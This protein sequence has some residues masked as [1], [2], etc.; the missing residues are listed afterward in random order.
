MNPSADELDE[1]LQR[2]YRYALALT[3][4]PSTAE[5]LVQE[6]CVAIARH[7]GPWQAGYMFSAVRSR[8]IDACRRRGLVAFEP[9]G[10]M[11]FAA[12]ES[13]DTSLDGTLENALARLKPGDRELL[14]LAVVEEYST[15]EIAAL[16]GRPL[17]TVLSSIHRA[18][19][20]LREWLSPLQR[21]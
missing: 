11:E 19:L 12:A 13:I 18:K 5:D 15:K 21:T 9:I 1:L 7:G 20:K 17:G 14:L 16:T 6:A 10:P 4:D 2:A 8:F 3:H